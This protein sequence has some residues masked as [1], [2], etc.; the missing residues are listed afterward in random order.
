MAEQSDKRYFVILN[1]H[2]G[3]G[4][5]AKL[6]P[7][8][9]ETLRRKNLDFVL[10]ETQG[11]GHAEKLAREAPPDF[12]VIVAAGGDGTANEVVNG[13]MKNPRPMGLIPTGSGNDFARAM[14]IPFQWQKAI[15][16]LIQNQEKR[17][18]VGWVNGRYFPNGFGVGFDA[19][20][21]LESSKVTRLR[22][23]LIY[24]YSVLKSIFFYS[25]P[26]LTI[27]LDNR[28]KIEGRI[29]MLTVGNGVSLGGGFLLTPNAQNNDGIFDVCVIHHLSKPQI[30][31]HLPKVFWG[32]HVKIKPVEMLQA[33]ELVVKST[34]PVGGHVDGEIVEM[35]RQEFRV[36]IFPKAL[37]VIGGSPGE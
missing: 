2:S 16:V 19:L 36:K 5:A 26:H 29:F 27:H 9:E 31:W 20:V 11:Q 12:D 4:K 34:G 6:R 24:L 28:H 25:S 14:A 33:K 13:L 17:I 18:D 15:D 22:G 3:R 32:G 21:V 30:F 7:K 35:D 10:V 23:F 1:P 8:I 37:S